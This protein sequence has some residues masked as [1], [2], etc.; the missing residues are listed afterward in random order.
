LQLLR[1][2]HRDF[3]RVILSPLLSNILDWIGRNQ[4]LLSRGVE[5]LKSVGSVP[6]FSSHPYRHPIKPAFNIGGG[7]FRENAIA[8]FGSQLD[9]GLLDYFVGTTFQFA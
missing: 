3:F 2:K 7:N 9:E 8:E 4:L 1:R 5:D 6:L